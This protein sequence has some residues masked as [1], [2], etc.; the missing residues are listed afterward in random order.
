[1]TVSMSK[2]CYYAK[3][4][5]YADVCKIQDFALCPLIME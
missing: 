4:C 5:P 3:K 2:T 1:M